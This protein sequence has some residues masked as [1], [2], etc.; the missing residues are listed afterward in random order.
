MT[1]SFEISGASYRADLS[2]PI[3]ISI[4]IHPD[5]PRAWYVDKMMFKPVMTD[6]FTGSVAKG[7][8]VNF[9]NIAFNP[10]GHGTHTETVGHIDAEIVS[11]NKTL[12]KFFFPARLISVLPTPFAGSEDSYKKHGDLIITKE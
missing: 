5:G 2:L 3:D 7:G 8:A 10:H 4:P 9:R 12:T 1:A 6:R 11:V